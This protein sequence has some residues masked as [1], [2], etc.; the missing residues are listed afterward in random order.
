LG[1]PITPI[2]TPKPLATLRIKRGEAKGKRFSVLGPTVTMGR[3]DFNDVVID[4]PSISA[5]H[6]RLDLGEGIW[7]ITDLGST[8]GTTVDGVPV[9]DETP[10]SPG[11]TIELGQIVF[12]FEPHDGPVAVR[13]A[14]AADLPGDRSPAVPAAEAPAVPEPGLPN[15]ET[16]RDRA[17]YHPILLTAGRGRARNGKLLLAAAVVGLALALAALVF[18][19]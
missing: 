17:A 19:V 9:T 14:V 2:P 13:R 1:L 11:A 4:D 6:A 8:N 15:A 10:L 3:A 7:S 18:L 12:S 16:A 5:A